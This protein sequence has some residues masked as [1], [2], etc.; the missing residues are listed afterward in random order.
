MQMENRSRV[1]QQ[2]EKMYI[3]SSYTHDKTTS[4]GPTLLIVGPLNVICERY[5]A[6]LMSHATA[7][8]GLSINFSDARLKAAQVMAKES[9]CLQRCPIMDGISKIDRGRQERH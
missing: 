9:Y 5:A 7:S 8:R 3:E 1:T 6:V 4:L 2:K